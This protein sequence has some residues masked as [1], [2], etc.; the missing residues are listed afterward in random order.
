MDAFNG[1]QNFKFLKLRHILGG[2]LTRFSGV[3]SW[4]LLSIKKGIGVCNSQGKPRDQLWLHSVP[5]G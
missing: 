3:G 1:L 4:M 2:A 5:E